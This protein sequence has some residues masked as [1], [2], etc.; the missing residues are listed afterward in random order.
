MIEP[1]A[2]GRAKCRGCDRRI[3][4]GEL[5]FGERLPNMFGDGEMTLWFH[6]ACAAYKRPE[7]FLETLAEGAGAALPDAAAL[8]AAARRGIDHRRLPRV[9]GAERAPTGRA[10]CRH[11]R[12]PIAKGAWRV[13]LV[14]FDEARF[15][16]SGFVHAEC[17]EAY[18]GTTELIDRARH[19][20]P[21]LG[22]AD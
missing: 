3:A 20:N 4:K 11:C 22:D 15:E 14:Y 21:E 10:R 6:P 2:S 16:P 5:R 12:E 1:A 7:P 18:F 19:F 17:A 8:E 13:P 9:D